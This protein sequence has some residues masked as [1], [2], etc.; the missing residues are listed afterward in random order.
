M[1]KDFSTMEDSNRSSNPSIHD[2]SSPRRRTLL[3]GG[4]A[5]TVSGVLAPLS[6]GVAVAAAA[7]VSGC[8]TTARSGPLLGFKSV[9][10]STADSV[11][12]PDGYSAH[13]IA[14]W[15]EPV[16]LSGDSPA[17][18]AD[19]SNS[20]SDQEAQLGMHPDGMAT[21]TAAKV[22]KA[23]AAQ[24]VSVVEVENKGARWEVVN[25]GPRARRI[26][27]STP[28]AFAGPA[29]ARPS[30]A[31]PWAAPRTKAPPWPPRP[32]AARWSIWAKTRALSTP[33]S[34]SRA[35][36]FSQAARLPMPRCWTTA[37]S[38]SHALML[39]AAAAG[40]RCGKARAR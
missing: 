6:G 11:T 39:T 8:A 25:P 15:G 38:S 14:A 4:L 5:G 20:A 17:F 23:Q 12:V 2:I 35:T 34:L 40:A 33:T 28:M 22:R 13:T 27:A 36:R 26:T 7:A 31:R 37:R 32:M 3:R 9:P 1:A 16:G 29:A 24:G 21:W 10:V 30:S 19:A 18:K